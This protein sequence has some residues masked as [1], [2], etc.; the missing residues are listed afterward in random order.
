MSYRFTGCE[1][2]PA[3]YH[4][5][6]AGDR[7]EIEPKAFDVL[8]YLLRHRDRMVAKD[9]L[10]D[11]LWPGQVVG[12]ATLTRC[13]GVVRKAVGD[14]RTKQA[15]IETQHGRGY[16]FVATVTEQSEASTPNLSANGTASTS[17]GL[18]DEPVSAPILVSL[19]LPNGHEVNEHEVSVVPAPV[20]EHPSV[21]P[22][23]A[24]AEE[25]RG[26]VLP[27]PRRQGGARWLFTILLLITGLVVAVRYLP[28]SLTHPHSLPPDTQSLPLPDKPSVAVLSFIN[29]TEDPKQEFLADGIAEGV[30][31]GLVKLPS[32]FVISRVSS[33]TYKGK[34]VKVREVSRELGVRY[35]L[36]GSVQKAANDHIRVTAQLID[37]IT[38]QH[39]WAEQYDRPAQDMF[40][41]RDDI[42]RKLVVHIAPKMT[43]IE[44]SRLER[45]YTGSLE[46]YEYYLRGTVT[47]QQ[48]G[49]PQRNV[50]GRQS[51]EK[52]V[53]LDS[54]YAAAYA[55][56][57]FA[58]WFDWLYAWTQDPHAIEN[59]L[60]FA[61]KALKLDDS[62]P[63]AH[64]LVGLHYL[65]HRQYEQAI[66]EFERAIELGPSWSSTYT[67]LGAT[68][69]AIGRSEEAIPLIQKSVRYHT[70]YPFW[71]ANYL[72]TLGDSYR[73]I[74][75]YDKAIE[76]FKKSISTFPTLGAALWLTATYVES[77][78]EP[79]A[80]EM[81][82]RIQKAVPR[83]SLDLLQ[84]QILYQDPAKTDRILAA[85][86]K[87]GLK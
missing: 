58:Y 4:L 3:R 56:I 74:G 2:D 36:T 8:V 76:T 27:P 79:L 49:D 46:A 30:I 13:I 59:M 34:P 38:D 52:A 87:A 66:V 29:M 24:S 61:Q 70:R 84:P 21:S 48:G 44:Q 72:H 22:V 7:I 31:T 6:R 68:L 69:N 50:Q 35:V 60:T 23:L 47:M 32:V 65:V 33:F 51:C 41:V 17:S 71:T 54:T 63:T 11:K 81:A 80:Q 5:Y 28:F 77:G 10:L 55:C 67:A 53:E 15:V 20:E 85:L 9:E 18:N 16:R 26:E 82:E 73:L 43:P 1:L 45:A 64:E 25:K 62:L 12:E 19:P 14:D 83:F 42:T 78:Q 39:V 37:G 40:A 86:R 57:G 75:Q